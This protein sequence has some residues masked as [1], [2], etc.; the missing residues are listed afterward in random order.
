MAGFQAIRRNGR[1]ELDPWIETEKTSLSAGFANGVK[2][3]KAAVGAVILSGWS[4]GQA[5]GQIY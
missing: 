2:K 1:T 5:E 4:I 3:D